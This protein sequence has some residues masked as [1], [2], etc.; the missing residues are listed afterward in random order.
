[1]PASKAKSPPAKRKQDKS[2]KTVSPKKKPTPKKRGPKTPW[3]KSPKLIDKIISLI[4]TD[5]SFKDIAKIAG[6]PSYATL[7]RL[8]GEDPDF[9]ARIA[10]A[11]EYGQAEAVVSAMIDVEKKLETRKIDPQAARVLIW[12]KQWRAGKM[13]QKRYGEK[14]QVEGTVEVSI[15]SIIEEVAAR[16]REEMKTI[17]ARPVEVVDLDNKAR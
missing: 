16:R 11:R 10:R 8:Q 6:M 13:N 2:K 15:A 5:H 12:S 4:E 14:T 3:T 17:E 7:L 9:A 1:L